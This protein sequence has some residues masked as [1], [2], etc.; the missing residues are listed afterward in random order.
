MKRKKRVGKRHE[1]MKTALG[2]G[3][4]HREKD[5][6]DS[7]SKEINNAGLPPSLYPSVPHFLLHS[8]LHLLFCIFLLRSFC[9]LFASRLS[10]FVRGL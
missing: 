3:S 8:P 7:R 10:F 4:Q 9:L 5:L 6:N 1:G 2:G